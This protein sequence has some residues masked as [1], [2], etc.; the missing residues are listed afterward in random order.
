MPGGPIVIV[1]FLLG[2]LPTNMPTVEHR[3][4]QSP[5]FQF[6]V[7]R[8][9]FS[10]A[11]D[12]LRAGFWN[13][14]DRK[15]A[16]GKIENNVSVFI[17]YIRTVSHER[18]EFDPGD[19]KKLTQAQ[20]ASETLNLAQRLRPELRRVVRNERSAVVPVSYWEFLYKLESDLLR[21]KWM[22]AQLH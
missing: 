20:L 7:A 13:D 6:S 4:V 2:Q 10:D 15:K 11:V 19:L 22:S 1:L 16:A 12:Q 3:S 21:L 9:E 18:P 5:L 17:R 14:K 8:G